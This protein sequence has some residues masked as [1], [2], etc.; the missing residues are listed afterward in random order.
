MNRSRFATARRDPLRL[1]TVRSTNA[2]RDAYAAYD[3][4]RYGRTAPVPGAASARPGRHREQRRKRA[5]GAAACQ[6]PQ[7]SNVATM[8]VLGTG[9][10]VLASGIGHRPL[11]QHGGH[12]GQTSPAQQLDLGRPDPEFLPAVGC[13]CLCAVNDIRALT[14]P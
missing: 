13:E 12:Q 9:V 2:G 14:R 8:A 11:Q 4:E 1:V 5:V 7:V 3:E 10:L 6:S